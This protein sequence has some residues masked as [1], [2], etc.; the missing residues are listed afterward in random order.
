[1][2]GKVRGTLDGTPLDHDF[3]RFDHQQTTIKK[4]SSTDNIGM[5]AYATEGWAISNRGWMSTLS[6][7]NLQTTGIRVVDK[8]GK[9][10]KEIKGNQPVYA[11]LTAPL[12]IHQDQ[13][14]QG[15]IELT[16]PKGETSRIIVKETMNDS[17][18]F[19]AVLPLSSAGTWT[20]SY[21]YWGFKKTATIMLQK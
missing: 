10:V 16:S 14:D 2:L 3:P 19:R 17:G 13:P 21:G 7:L 8:K 20:L 15:W 1:M 4:D 6:F 12:N 11:E 5:F 9:T 18:V